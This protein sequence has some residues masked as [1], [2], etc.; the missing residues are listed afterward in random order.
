MVKLNRKGFTLVELLAVIVVLAIIMIIA[1]P[2]VMNTM[3]DAQ[4]GTFKIYAEKVLNSA[5]EK[6]Q[7]DLML[8]KT[9]GKTSYGYC[10][11]ISTH[12]GLAA[13]AN[14][15]GY[16]VVTLDAHLK[17]AF[18][19]TL[20]DNNFSVKDYQYAKLSDT[21]TFAIPVATLTCPTTFTAPVS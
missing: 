20:S 2:S 10:Y 6:Y 16:V 5:Q 9:E 14:Y 17:P 7:T 13:T 18:Y 21:D 15:R 19:V 1:I 3:N 4:R 8:G 11:D 12:L